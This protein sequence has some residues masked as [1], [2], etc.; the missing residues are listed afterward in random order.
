MSNPF[1]LLFPWRKLPPATYKCDT[2]QLP[3]LVLAKTNRPDSHQKR[4]REFTGWLWTAQ[5]DGWLTLSFMSL[6][7]DSIC[8]ILLYTLR[9]KQVRT[10]K[11]GL[12]FVR[13][14]PLQK[15]TIKAQTVEWLELRQSGKFYVWFTGSLFIRWFWANRALG[16]NSGAAAKERMSWNCFFC[17]FF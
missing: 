14:F 7:W 4:R 6:W 9:I 12:D 8:I 5:C 13:L 15:N 11:K 17:C 1:A 10:L 16:N 3:M 2:K